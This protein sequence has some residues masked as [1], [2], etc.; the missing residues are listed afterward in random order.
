MKGDREVAEECEKGCEVM[1]KKGKED[2]GGGDGKQDEEHG[3][4]VLISMENGER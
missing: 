2:E 3:G 1:E 4:L